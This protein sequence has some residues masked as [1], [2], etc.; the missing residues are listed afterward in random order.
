MKKITRYFF[1]FAVVVCAIT[2]TAAQTSFKAIL[3]G[4]E[5]VPPVK[6]TAIGEASFRPVRGGKVLAYTLKVSE[7]KDV[8][9]AHIHIGKKGENGPPAVFLFHGPEKKGRFSGT[10]AEGTISGKD[11]FGPL[12]GKSIEDLMAKINS[13]DAYVVVHTEQNPG[14]ELRG[15]IR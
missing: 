5:V 8:T 13:G 14:G 11:L 4:G 12:S 7:I 3:A 15:Q 9:A 6:T 10:L 2:A 1:A